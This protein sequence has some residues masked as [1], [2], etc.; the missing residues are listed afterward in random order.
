MDT[1]NF[2]YFFGL[3]VVGSFL[4]FQGARVMRIGASAH[5]AAIERLYIQQ[6]KEWGEFQRTEF[7]GKQALTT[8]V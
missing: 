1:S 3:R 7:R 4:T 2:V 6:R 5:R 8:I